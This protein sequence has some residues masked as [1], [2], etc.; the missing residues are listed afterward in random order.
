MILLRLLEGRAHV[1]EDFESIGQA[2]GFHLQEGREVDSLRDLV[3][4]IRLDNV[5][6]A[7]LVGDQHRARRESR[8]THS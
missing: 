7:V 8:R 5:H 6:H 4:S 3:D 1:V 2:E